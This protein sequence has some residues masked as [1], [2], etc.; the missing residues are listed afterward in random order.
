MSS[1]FSD[2]IFGSSDAAN[3]EGLKILW[4]LLIRSIIIWDSN[5]TKTICWGGPYYG[6]VAEGK[7]SDSESSDHFVDFFNWYSAVFSQ[8]IRSKE[9]LLLC[10]YWELINEV[11]WFESQICSGWLQGQL[12]VVF[13]IKTRIMVRV[14]NPQEYIDLRDLIQWLTG[15]N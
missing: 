2:V 6:M 3:G 14:R 1:L 12:G 10:D 5:S 7:V 11:V 4:R 8:Y 9:L 13:S 15:F